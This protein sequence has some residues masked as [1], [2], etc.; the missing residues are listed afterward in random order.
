VNWAP[1]NADPLPGMVRLW[2][3]EA[4][5]HG[6]EAVC[7]FRWRQ[8]PFAQEQM[9]A[10]LLRPDSAPAPALDEARQVAAEIGAG[11][12]RPA[13][14][15]ADCAILFD[16]ESAWAWEIQPHSQGFSHLEAALAQYRQLRR[17]GLDVDIL[18][19]RTGD[20]SGYRVVFIPALFA[21]TEALK[22]KLAGH[23]GLIVIGPRSGSKTQDFRIPAALPPDLPPSLF[24]A[25]VMRVDSL[26]ADVLV[27]I[28]GGGNVVMWR[29]KL[30]TR[31]E[32]HVES[33]DGWPV[34]I[35]QGKVL[36]LAGLLDEAAHTAITKRLAGMAGL[37]IRELPAG[38][39]TRRAGDR[40]FV[41]NYGL[42]T[43]DL[44]ALGFSPPFGLGGAKLGP[45][46]VATASASR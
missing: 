26:A 41:F 12:T 45:G 7:Y 37:T 24:D 3:W 5:A 35:G 36:Y 2:T 8:A 19:A 30:E 29:E 23:E 21:W 10:G 31:A 17:L 46:G 4:F 27:P 39:R 25:K 22:A 9:H 15:A 16:Y 11:E 1:H 38:L 42:E 14:N 33:E 43:H 40:M 28:K 44:A 6:A 34:L 13:V 32:I 18:S 20:L